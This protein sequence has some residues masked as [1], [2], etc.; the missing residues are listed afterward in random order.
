MKY[1]KWGLLGNLSR[2]MENCGAE[3]DLNYVSLLAQ[4]DSMDC[5]YDI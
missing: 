3:V 1:F 2:D 4:D 5:L